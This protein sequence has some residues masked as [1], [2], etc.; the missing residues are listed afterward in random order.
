[1]PPLQARKL[2]GRQ[3]S[4]ADDRFRRRSIS[5]GVMKHLKEPDIDRVTVEIFSM[6][7][8]AHEVR[9]GYNE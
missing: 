6:E 7:R 2:N 8:I 3:S 9:F 4:S 1:M 5:R